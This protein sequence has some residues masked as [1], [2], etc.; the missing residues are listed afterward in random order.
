MK[1]VILSK[2]F[3]KKCLFGWLIFCTVIGF[4]FTLFFI[5]EYI[6]YFSKQIS[7]D[8]RTPEEHHNKRELV[9]YLVL[10]AEPNITIP[11]HFPAPDGTFID[12]EAKINR[13]RFRYDDIEKQKPDDVKRIFM[14]GGSVVFNGPTNQTTI[15][16]FLEKQLSEQDSDSTYQVINAGMTAYVSTQEL[17][18]LTTQILDFNPDLVIVLDGYNDCLIPLTQDERLGYPFAFKTLESAWYQTTF[19]LKGMRQFSWGTHLVS[20]S[21]LLRAINPNLSYT[22]LIESSRIKRRSDEFIPEADIPSAAN[23]LINNWKKMADILKVRNIDGL[24]YLQPMPYEREKFTQFYDLVEGEI[25]ELNTDNPEFQFTSLRTFLRDR[26]DLFYD[27]IHTYVEG[28]Q[29][30]ANRMM[31]DVIRLDS[32]Q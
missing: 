28:N 22:N 27:D 21:H 3:L 23:L 19:I 13:F 18:L 7:P 12:G 11:T 20:G 16:G 17:I 25:E 26:L 10:Q 24:F 32:L 29:L 2:G 5:A 4:L 1:G 14:L 15:S 31:E 6:T 8:F 9:P 30:Y